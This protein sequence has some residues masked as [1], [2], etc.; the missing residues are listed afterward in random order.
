MKNKPSSQKI[1]FLI[2][3]IFFQNLVLGNELKFNA[4]EIETFDKGNL[5]KGSGGVKIDDGS[6]ISITSE[7]F[8]LDKIKSVL[9]A[10]ENVVAKDDLNENFFKS[11]EIIFLKKLNTLVSKNKTII[12]LDSGHI[13]ETSNITY[14][15]NLNKIS[16]NKETFITDLDNNKSSMSGFNFFTMDKVL[17]ASNV[18]IIDKE[19]NTYNLE[20]I[21][22]NMKTNE[23]LGKDLSLN[24]NNTNFG[25]NENE[26]RLK[27]NSFSLDENITQV[28]S[29]VFTTC[30]KND[31]CPPWVLRSEK[32]QHDKNKKIIN[33][34]NALLKVYDIPVLYFPK[35]FHPDPTVKRQSGFLVPSFSQSN[36]Y[37]NFFSTPYFFAISKSS[38]LTFSPRIYDNGTAIYQS[39]YRN[40]RKSSQHV[41]DFS[42]RNKNPL[43]L[44]KKNTPSQTHFFL[45]SKFKLDAVNF[46]EANIDLKI[47]QTSDDEYLKAYKIKSPLIESEDVLHSSIDFNLS[48]D[49]LDIEI[50]TEIYENLT[51]PDNDRYEYIYPGFSVTKDIKETNKGNFSLKTVGAN[52]L[53]NTNVYEKTLVN[54]L[55]YKSFNKISALGLVSNYEILFK[56]FNSDSD[57]SPNYKNQTE[58][59]LQSIVNYVM[60]YPLQK[61]GENFLSTLTPIVSVKYSP[62]KSKNISEHD[63]EINVDNVFALN[64]I[65][66]SDTVEG[67]QSITIGNEYALYDN[68]NTGKK[69]FSVDLATS[70]RDEKNDKLPINSTLGEEYSDIFGSISFDANKFIDLDYNFS[71]DNDLET[72][73][74]SQIKST[75][76]FNNFVTTFDFLEKS[77]LMGGNSFVSNESKLQIN[78]SSSLS[79]KTRENKEKDITE[80]Y[81]LIYE[82]QNDCLIAGLEFKKDF[83]TDG[84]LKPDEQLFFSITI[85]P[86]GKA[87]SPN[88]NQ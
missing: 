57:N 39:E 14:N 37:G 20:N 61:I 60:K 67:G 71:L 21:S 82:Y 27:G 53:Y 8:E 45:E 55:T 72:L 42:I 36:N 77:N 74:M 3:F 1:F 83:Y 75:L 2:F 79:F 56:N 68:D 23:I 41:T 46:D 52:K 49:D 62:N 24:F 6:G 9:K 32:I 25:S 13:I 51:R 7:K 22:Y 5:I 65:G 59:S 18:R 81:N 88:I 50:T 17:T 87:V 16:S 26:P 66:S 33:Y 19:G 78:K 12:E 47:Q 76:S 58:N 34:K 15:R 28:N 43:S 73:N 80:Y 31:S 38:D 30:K 11:D 44:D 63:R 70:F 29:G 48:R 85:M 69:L 86:F 84:S 54:D 40:Y 4:S 10:K 64:R 35:F